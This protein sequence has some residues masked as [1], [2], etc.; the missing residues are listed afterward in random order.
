MMWLLLLW[1][2]MFPPDR[3]IDRFPPDR[4]ID[5]FPPPPGYHRCVVTPGSYSE[6]LGELPLK[7]KGTPTRT[8]RGAIAATNPYTGAVVD[9]SVGSEDLQQCADAV[10]RLRGE[11]LYY[12]RRYKDIAFTFTSGFR[13]DYLHYAQGYRFRA[14]RW[15]LAAAPDYTYKTFMQYMRLVFMYCGTLSLEKELQPVKDARTLQAGDIFIHGGSPG[16][17]FIVLEAV[18]NDKGQRLLLLAQ[19]FMPAQNIQIV[20]VSGNPWFGADGGA[21]ALPYGELIQ[22]SYAKRF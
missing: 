15:V 6:W 10:M 17:C 19:S 5:R 16:H 4:V 9:M 1:C 18:E 13:C 7:P 22:L 11:Y 14:G 12:K 8:Y 3:V 20:Q 21:P 2:A